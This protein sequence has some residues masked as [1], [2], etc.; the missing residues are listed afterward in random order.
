MS[1][2]IQIVSDLHLEFRS[3][4]KVFNVI[5]PTAKVLALLGDICCTGD[6]SDMEIFKRFIIEIL[7]HYDH[8]IM[9]SGNHDPYFNPAKKTAPGKENTL[10]ASHT[11][12]KAFFSA[13]SKKL[14]YL[15]NSTLK[16][17]VGGKK[18]VIVGSTLWS[19]IPKEHQERIEGAMSDYQYIYVSDAK[20]NKIR[21]LKASDV[22]SMFNKNY[23]YI[24]GQID[25]AAAG[26]YKVIIFTHH[27]PYIDKTYDVNSH[28]PAYKSDCSAIVNPKVVALWAFGHCHERVDKVIKGVRYYSNCLGYPRERTGFDKTAKVKIQ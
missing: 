3:D 13:T 18:F 17:S 12:I 22:T 11:K 28:D 16:L 4:K 10:S 15:N 9:V 8:I 5:K 24:K 19:Y 2:E 25:K 14:H 6:A 1:L 27:R 23:R 21:S 7:P 20:T 26:N